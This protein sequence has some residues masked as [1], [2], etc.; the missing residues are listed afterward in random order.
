MK[1]DEVLDLIMKSAPSDY[2]YDDYDGLYMYNSDINLR[3]LL[4]KSD[5]FKGPFS[6]PWVSEFSDKPGERQLVRICYLATPICKVSCVWVDSFKSLIPIPR[7]KDLTIDPFK[8]KIGSIL[9]YA[10]PNQG[11]NFDEALQE[12]GITV[13][14]S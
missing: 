8:Y 1:K 4:D 9:N 13:Q 3:F 12:A 10:L 2:T 6:E 7:I 5:E 14:D 11:F